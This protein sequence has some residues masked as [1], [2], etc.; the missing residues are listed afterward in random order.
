M[1]DRW[2]AF[3]ESNTS[4]TGRLFARAAARQGLRPILLA[5]DPAR[6][7]Y[8]EQD[9]LDAL[10]VDTQDE[11]A[12]IEACRRLASAPGLAGVTS[13]SEYFIA[14]AAV[15]ASRLGLPGP[16][17]E[18]IR[19]CRDKHTQRLRL[20]AAGVG[21]PAFQA[22]GSA[23]EA[24]AAAERIGYPV[25]V[26]PVDG[27]GSVGVRLCGDPGEVGAHAGALLAQQRNERGLPVPRRVLVEELAVGPEY[28]VE[29]FGDRV[30]GVT[31]KHLGEP[32]S[33]VEVGH[34][35]PAVLAPDIER[36]IGQ[37]ARRALKALDLRWGPVHVELR[38]TPG[39]PAIIEVNPRLAGGYIPELVRLAVGVDL[40]GE[41]IRLVAGR[42]PRLRKTAGRYAS[43]RFILAAQD[44][45]LVEVGG[46]EVAEGMRGVEEVALY[47]PPGSLLRRS[48]DFRD[49]I[50]HVIACGDTPVGASTAAEQARRALQVRIRPD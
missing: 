33:F 12:L 3:V 31:R 8:V 24:V 47:A 19:A 22:A 9:G 2:L 11:Q 39:G 16:S 6:Y 40:I 45:V 5:A 46:R 10:R 42:V 17:A 38:L 50:G 25:V 30:V 14:T 41:T 43:I 27:S 28:S 48:G 20:R 15:I 32:P 26:K 7:R 49:R 21:V 29:V 34:D 1:T 44:G 13:S 23:D 18:A 35:F 36:A 4:G 37:A